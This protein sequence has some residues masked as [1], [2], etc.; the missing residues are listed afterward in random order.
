[1]GEQSQK[2][3]WWIELRWKLLIIPFLSVPSSW[4]CKFNPALPLNYISERCFEVIILGQSK[5]YRPTSA[6]GN[7][8]KLIK[9]MFLSKKKKNRQDFTDVVVHLY[10][11]FERLV[12]L[13][14][15]SF[16]W[17]QLPKL[18]RKKIF[19]S[20]SNYNST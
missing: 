13:P 20:S 18:S 11:S 5:N 3:P 17:S 7:S 8:K 1:M 9:R 2:S 10:G 15:P 4:S 16:L 19:C 14:F 12:F 6:L